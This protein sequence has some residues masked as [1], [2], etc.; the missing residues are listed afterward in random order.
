MELN[1]QKFYRACNPSYTLAVA[2]QE[3]RQYYIDFSS[4]RGGTIVEQLERTISRLS[5][6]A[7]TCQLFTGH[8][9]SGKS[10]ELLRLQAQLQQQGFHVVYFESSKDLDM[11]DVDITDILLSVARQVSESIEKMKI[12]LQPTGFKLCLKGLLMFFKLK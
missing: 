7:P 3:D 10:T 9:G 11:A 6:D 1:L 5:P 4:V 12:K 2:N 8:I